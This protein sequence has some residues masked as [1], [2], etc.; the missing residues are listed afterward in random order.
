MLILEIYFPIHH[1]LCY[2]PV[3][4]YSV[5]DCFSS[6]PNTISTLKCYLL[7]QALAEQI[8][9]RNEKMKTEMLG[10]FQSE[11]NC[12]V[13]LLGHQSSNVFIESYYLSLGL[14]SCSC[15]Q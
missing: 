1:P 14:P 12:F 11:R 13:S 3:I 2:V 6:R 15:G 4:N 9:D 7:L 5:D 10:E 8:H